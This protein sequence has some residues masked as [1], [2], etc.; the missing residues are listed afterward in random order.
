MLLL[1]RRPGPQARRYRDR[2]GDR[3]DGCL[4]G[5]FRHGPGGRQL[6]L[7]RRRGGG[8]ADHVHQPGQVHHLDPADQSRRG[9]DHLLGGALRGDAPHAPGTGA[10][11]QYVHG[12]FA[13][14][15][16]GLRTQGEPYHDAPPQAPRC[17]AYRRGDAVSDRA[18]GDADARLRLLPLLLRAGAGAE[19]RVR[20]HRGGE[21]LRLY[22][23][24][25]PL[26]LPL[27]AAVAFQDGLLL[28]PFPALRG[29]DDDLFAGAVC[30][31]AVY[32][33]AFP[34]GTAYVYELGEY[35]FCFNAD[36]WDCGV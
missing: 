10:L 17:P 22:R 36:V 29:G 26:Q 15:D 35:C 7:H 1:S 21:R 5:G 32:A 6:R 18:G 2:H 13:G 28:Q 19:Y 12:D 27:V 24:G 11:D 4:Q 34:D 16:A 14:A 20:P 31:P 25:L 3:R 8:G 33:G 9:D 30:L 23:D